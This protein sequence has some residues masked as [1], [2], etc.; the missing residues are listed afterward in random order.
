MV[1]EERKKHE[2]E[3]AIL[4][5]KLNEQGNNLINLEEVVAQLQK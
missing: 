1:E 4:H 3:V 2:E 5:D